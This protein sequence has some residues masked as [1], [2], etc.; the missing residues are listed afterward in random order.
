VIKFI[1]NKLKLKSLAHKIIFPN[2]VIVL[3][4]SVA[5]FTFAKYELEKTVRNEFR[6]KGESL[7]KS[8]ETGLQETLLN[9]STSAVQGFIDEYRSIDGVS[10]IIV[11]DEN[12]E[13]L[14]HTFTPTIPEQY[15]VFQGA[16]KG[17]KSYSTELNVAE[18]EVDGVDHFVFDA[19][20]LAGLLGRAII[21]MDVE[22]KAADVVRP[23]KE[24]F[25]VF[26]LG[27]FMAFSFFG[28]WIMN[29]ILAP[30]TSL[31]KQAKRYSLGLDVEEVKS[32]TKDEVGGLIKAFNDLIERNNNYREDLEEEVR[33][34]SDIII[35]Q[36][37]QISTSAR[38][39]MLGEMSAGIAH[40]INNPL[41]VL[42]TGCMILKKQLGKEDI[43]RERV[44]K[45]VE[46]NF[47]VIQRITKIIAGMK[48]VS[49]DGSNDVFEQANLREIFEDSLSICSA[50]FRNKN[51]K[52]E[53]NLNDP[54]F[55]TSFNCRHVEVSQIMINLLGNAFDAVSEL[56]KPW[57]KVSAEADEKYLT[58]RISDSGP[59]IP[60][61]VKQRIFIPFYTTKPVGKGTGIGL[62]L[63]LRI[64][65][66]HGGSISL[67]EA[68]EHTC[69]VIKLKLDPAK[70]V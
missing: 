18:V 34:R 21:G 25:A 20:I 54:I 4:T 1:K 55:D 39:S 64:A 27:I 31:T 69:F 51:V 58:I 49:R 52:L 35:Q 43:N 66:N 44:M 22:K 26:T 7:S 63:C 5:A 42:S 6:L 59:G 2:L 9:T 37:E 57:V 24:L 13:P 23:L 12:D 48:N 38:L 14:A 70:V 62:S 32:N 10:F 17:E 11:Y 61:D 60:E 3:L 46:D 16:N 67:D 40:E 41:T 19:P 15:R 45:I 47:K 53:C 56:D 30:I 33:Q 65:N 50:R 68:S 8:L 36:K 28:I 29:R